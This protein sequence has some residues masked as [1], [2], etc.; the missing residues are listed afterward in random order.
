MQRPTESHFMSKENNYETQSK[1][2]PH[3][4]IYQ[5]LAKHKSLHISMV[6]IRGNE[7]RQP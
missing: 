6:S 1:V 7:L 5:T 2:K 4:I 3:V